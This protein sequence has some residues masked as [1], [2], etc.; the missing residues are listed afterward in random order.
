MNAFECARLI[1]AVRFPDEVIGE[2]VMVKL[3]CA[4]VRPTDV[5]V[6]PFDVRQEFPTKMQPPVT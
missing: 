6:P 1:V 3:V 5:T 4:S 2:L